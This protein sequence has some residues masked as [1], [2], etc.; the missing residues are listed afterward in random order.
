MLIKNW[1]LPAT[2]ALH[3]GL[4]LFITAVWKTGGIRFL[5]ESNRSFTTASHSKYYWKPQLPACLWGVPINWL[6]L[7]LVFLPYKAPGVIRSLTC[8]AIC[9]VRY[10][11]LLDI[12]YILNF[13]CIYFAY[14]MMSLIPAILLFLSNLVLLYTSL[15]LVI[16]VSAF[17][18]PAK[19]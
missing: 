10:M 16:F 4:A 11:Y 17:L 12:I 1:F 6:K 18:R 13:I 3:K 14:W 8:R 19:Q 15:C 5:Q 9:L 2:A 7:I